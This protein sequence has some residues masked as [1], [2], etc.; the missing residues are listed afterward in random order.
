MPAVQ[1][2][3]QE[4]KLEPFLGSQVGGSLSGPV[5]NNQLLSQQEIL[6]DQRS[7]STRPYQLS[8]GCE[9]VK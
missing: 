3:G 8:Q 9:Q 7:T 1:K 2:E 5:M 4:S 6:R